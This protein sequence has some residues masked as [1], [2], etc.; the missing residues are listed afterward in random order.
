MKKRHLLSYLAGTF[1]S[2]LFT[3]FPTAHAITLDKSSYYVGDPVTATNEGGGEWYT[4]YRLDDN[5][6]PV[7]QGVPVYYQY[8][9]MNDIGLGV[10]HYS[11]LEF[12][13]ADHLDCSTLVY[14]DCKTTG[15][16]VSEA[17]FT[18]MPIPIDGGGAGEETQASTAILNPIVTISSPQEGDVFSQKGTISYV[19]LNAIK[20]NLYYSNKIPLR[21]GSFVS[22]ADTISIAS[23]VPK[24]GSYSW[25]THLLTP[26]SLYRVIVDALGTDGHMGEMVSG[27]FSVDFTPPTFIVKADPPATRGTPVTIS[28]DASEV[29]GGIPVV[30]VTQVGAAVSAVIMKGN[31]LHFEGV[32]TPVPGYDGVAGIA[33][34]GVD[35][36]GNKGSL[37]VS[38]GTLAVGVNPP[39]K[40]V[41][42]SP[43]TNSVVATSTLSIIGTVRAD[44]T[45]MVE[46]NGVDTYEAKPGKDGVFTVPKIRLQAQGRGANVLSITARD[47]GGLVSEAVPISIRYNIPPTIALSRPVMNATLIGTAPLVAADADANADPL[48]FTYQIISARDYALLPLSSLFAS[49]TDSAW[50]I[51][52][53]A[54]PADRFNWDSTEV[55]NGLYYVR[56]RVDDGVAQAYTDPVSVSI[57]NVLPFL[58]FE[59]GRKTVSNKTPLVVTGHALVPSDLSVNAAIARVEYSTDNGKK[60]T[61]VPLV[62]DATGARFATT[63][64]TFTKEGTYPV[65]WRVTDD[66]KLVGRVSHPVIIDLT[67]PAAPLVLTPA[68]NARV[69]DDTDTNPNKQGVQ[70]IV[71]GT[72]EPESVVTLTFGSTVET[73]KAL[74]DGIF[75]FRDVNVTSRGRN[76]V[77]LTATDQAE[78]TSGPTTT[79]FLYDNPP[80]ISFI[81]P[82][83]SHGFSDTAD[84]QWKIVNRD[85][86]PLSGVALSWHRGNGAF[87]TLPVA[88]TDTSYV[89]DVMHLSEAVDYELRLIVGDGLATS[90]ETVGFAI[91]RTPPTL[92]SLVL[93]KTVLGKSDVLKATGGASDALSGI[94]AV[95]YALTARDAS[96]RED[97]WSVALLRNGYLKKSASYSITYPSELTDGAYRLFVRAVD[98]AGNVSPAQS[99]DITVDTAS[100]YVGSFEAVKDGLNITP[101]A[102][103][104]L[105]VYENS[106]FLFGISLEADTVSASVTAGE[107]M[108]ELTRNIAS[109]LWE[110]MLTAPAAG[111]TPLL[112]TAK[113]ASHNAETAVRF[114]TLATIP[115]GSVVAHGNTI[116]GALVRVLKLNEQTNAYVPFVSSQVSTSADVAVD[117]NGAY[118]LALPQGTFRLIVHAPG[119]VTVGQDSTFER[120]SFVGVSFTT[121]RQQGFLGF[122]KGIITYLHYGL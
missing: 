90:T 59:D 24:S 49:S 119:Y 46:V 37:V 66:R 93:A 14:A 36:A 64:S 77:R 40:P 3:F 73:T 92:T 39:P 74:F 44:T 25:D 96:P 121:E 65:L 112:L 15:T 62:T 41:V 31:G 1:F 45:A 42:T 81:T 4:I 80:I 68:P 108:T 67:P 22:P 104:V 85:K 48:A 23:D 72:A 38:G 50:T 98:A 43:R 97:D 61:A 79:S 12:D 13:P 69:G 60:W 110:G 35:K 87:T 120:P 63:F 5:E 53:D 11:I 6:L 32:Y 94:A 27:L 99:A 47:Q 114:G 91:D 29:L 95:E 58:R 10:G 84:I 100:P 111:A 101:D 33:V 116:P 115:R 7:R 107:R 2:I 88:Q 55:E 78:N 52:G 16:L 122:L 57:H 106:T 9:D 56:V 89:W 118:E 21:D 76:S 83:S 51:I 70:T 113:D 102:E 71:S 54:L 26:G 18:M 17:L 30:T 34:S 8:Q 75:A 20:V 19:T 103:G 117:E 105:T 28:V 86:V 82:Q 109:G